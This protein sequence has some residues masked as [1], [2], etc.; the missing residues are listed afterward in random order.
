[1]GLILDAGRRRCK[2]TGSTAHCWK[3][4]HPVL[5]PAREIPKVEANTNQLF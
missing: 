5:P 2:V 1:M 4:K 3:A